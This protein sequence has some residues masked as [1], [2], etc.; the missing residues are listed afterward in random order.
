M[1]RVFLPLFFGI[2]FIAALAS[3]PIWAP[4]PPPANV[5]VI[6]S[7]LP[8]SAVTLDSEGRV[9]VTCS[10]ENLSDFI[11]NGKRYTCKDAHESATPGTISH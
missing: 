2:V 11:V 1:K 9:K 10:S 6:S 8:M 4:D 7:H 3:L 5:F